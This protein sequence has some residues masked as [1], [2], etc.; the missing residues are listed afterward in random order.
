VGEGGGI[1]GPVCFAGRMKEVAEAAPGRGSFGKTFG[2]QLY[3]LIY[4]NVMLARRN[5]ISTAV[6]LFAPA[7]C[8]LLF[9]LT[10]ALTNRT[11]VNLN[12]APVEVLGGDGTV[13]RK[14]QVFDRVGG[15]F[16]LGGIIPNAECLTITYS[17]DNAETTAIMQKLAELNDLD[18]ATDFQGFA[19]AA[20]VRAFL[21]GGSIPV[22]ATVAFSEGSNVVKRVPGVKF[23]NAEQ[24]N[25]SAEQTVLPYEIWYNGTVMEGVFLATG[26]TDI[27]L[28]ETDSLDTYILQVQRSVN[29]A[30]VAVHTGSTTAGLKVG[31]RAF[32]QDTSSDGNSQSEISSFIELFGA[33]FYLVGIMISFIITL[34]QVVAE[35]DN[36]ILDALRMMGLY[37]S[38]YWLSWFITYFVMMGFSAIL[39]V[40][41]GIATRIEVFI[42]SDF[43]WMFLLFW[44]Y[45]LTM[46]TFAMFLSSLIPDTKVAIMVGFL[47]LACAVLFQ[48]FVS[49]QVFSIIDLMYDPY[50]LP[51]W[52]RNM[53]NLYPPLLYA[54]I[55][56]N[57]AGY[58]KARTIEIAPGV[59][60]ERHAQYTFDVAKEGS[61]QYIPLRL[62]TETVEVDGAAICSNVTS[63]LFESCYAQLNY[64]F[65][66]DAQYA[67][68]G[69]EYVEVASKCLDTPCT[70]QFVF[71][72]SESECENSGATFFS[73]GPG[74]SGCLCQF[75]LPSDASSLGYMA[76]IMIL[77]VVG[78][79]YA[80]QILTYGHG[81]A[82]KP[83]FIFSPF[84]WA[85]WLT[86]GRKSDRSGA[87]PTPSRDVD[88]DVLA[89]QEA[90]K[91]GE[92]DNPE[93]Y[94]IV[95]KELV[96]DFHSGILPAFGK[97]FRAVNGISISMKK[98][99]VFALLGHNGA[100]KTTAINMLSGLI[101]ISGGD[102]TVNG[103][104]VRD[105][106]AAIRHDV[107]VCPQFDLLFLELTAREHLRFYGHF[108]GMSLSEVR[109]QGER[110][111][112][113]VHLDRVNRKAGQFSGGMRRRLSMTV[114]AM[115]NKRICFLDEPSTGL[116]PQ[117]T[118]HLWD[119]I[120]DLKRSGRVVILTTH[121]LEEADVLGDKI[122]IMADGKMVALG[123]SLHLKSKFGGQYRVSFSP[124][125][126]NSRRELHEAMMK[127]LPAML[128]E[129]DVLE[130]GSGPMVYTIPVEHL[131]EAGRIF[132]YVEDQVD[133]GLMKDMSLAQTSLEDI[134]LSLDKE[135]RELR[136]QK[137]GEVPMA[138][139]VPEAHGGD[140]TV[141]PAL[142]FADTDKIEFH[143]SLRKQIRGLMLKNFVLQKRQRK[144]LFC[145]IFIPL[146]LIALMKTISVLISNA[147]TTS[148][149]E[150][151]EA[152]VDCARCIERAASDILE[153]QSFGSGAVWVE[154]LYGDPS[155]MTAQDLQLANSVQ[156][157][158][159]SGSSYYYG[160]EFY[161]NLAEFL[162]SN[163]DDAAVFT[164]AFVGYTACANA[165]TEAFD[166]CES[167]DFQQ[168]G[169]AAFTFDLPLWFSSYMGSEN[170]QVDVTFDSDVAPG[171]IR[172]LVGSKSSAVGAI[173]GE[174][175][176]NNGILAEEISD[177]ATFLEFGTCNSFIG[178]FR[179]SSSITPVFEVGADGTP[180]LL[181]KA[182]NCTFQDPSAALQ[183]PDNL[184][185]AY[186]DSKG[187]GFLSNWPTRIIIERRVFSEDYFFFS[188]N[189][190]QASPSLCRVETFPTFQELP[191]SLR[192][193]EDQSTVA[194]EM[195]YRA[196][197]ARR[198]G[199]GAFTDTIPRSPEGFKQGKR[200]LDDHFPSIGLV[201]EE[202]DVPAGRATVDIMSYIG[203]DPCEFVFGRYKFV[204]V[205]VTESGGSGSGSGSG[206]DPGECDDVLVTQETSAG[207]RADSNSF[208]FDPNIV[209]PLN[210]VLNGLT[211]AML[212]ATAGPGPI[213]DME[214]DVEISVGVRAMPQRNEEG[215][216]QASQQIIDEINKFFGSLMV[217]LA[218]SFLLPVLVYTLVLEKE[219]KLR[220]ALVQTGMRMKAY[221]IV[222]FIFGFGLTFTTMLLIYI[223]G[224]ALGI[225]VF[226]NHQ[227]AVFIILL[228]LWSF[229]LVSFSFF[230]STL[231]NKP[232]NS[233]IA[234]YLLVFVSVI[235]SNI[236]NVIVFDPRPFEQAAIWW[237]WFPLF[238]YYRA[239]YLLSTRSYFFEDMGPGDEL[240]KLFGVMFLQ[241]LVLLALAFYFD[242]V[243]PKEFGLNRQPCFC[244]SDFHRMLK[245]RR[246][247]R[248][249]D[250]TVDP[251]DYDDDDLEGGEAASEEDEDPDV[252][253][254]RKFVMSRSPEV[255]ESPIRIENMV[256]V[257]GSVRANDGIYLHVPNRTCLGLLGANGSGKTTL[258]NIISG[259]FAPTA[260]TAFINGYSIKTDMQKIH[261]SLGVC[262][263]HD[264]VYPLLTVREHLLL[265]ARMKGANKA[266]E[267]E[268]VEASLE[269]VELAEQAEKR[270]RQLSGG[271]RR[272]LSIAIAFIGNPSIVLLDEPSTGIDVA[273]AKAIGQLILKEKKKRTL[274]LTTHSMQEAEKLSDNI[275][276]MN[277]GKLQAIGTA[278]ALK[279]KYSEGFKL[280]LSV[281]DRDAAVRFIEK[282]FPGVVLE[283][284]VN[285]KITFRFEATH[286]VRISEV[287]G[288][289]TNSAEQNGISDFGLRLTSLEEVFVALASAA[290]AKSADGTA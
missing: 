96:K 84:Y 170:Q 266:D 85:P 90:I 7:V 220:A 144:T 213:A 64:C 57:M 200:V 265:Y 162:A 254:E 287:Y 239:V 201:F 107:S 63:P 126:E 87:L 262:P 73:V 121:L 275:A 140:T 34:R 129:E 92:H 143:P 124:V 79:W 149:G 223:L 19:N 193:L 163:P 142:N 15:R 89:E 16:G 199:T 8:V 56:N 280:L 55:D 205:D 38:A 198:E 153:Y 182:N 9:A 203:T 191:E 139:A 152:F 183:G 178:T 251:D 158:F 204:N 255:L 83:W 70:Q 151:D 219:L 17:P 267:K 94:P 216:G 256:R 258:T 58:V 176:E 111:L 234:L 67:F 242:A 125:D 192:S 71:S 59:R 54:K 14:C 123:D 197:K 26:G 37:E 159:D 244:F 11:S 174:Q 210:F 86:R 261:E 100:G 231:F 230:L 260:G 160:G 185:L 23:S 46:S 186:S 43:S 117:N 288:L 3:A 80:G 30:I 187:S 148:N 20:A 99:E 177:D 227:A 226:S 105:S 228:L 171:N 21:E 168:Q 274:I 157:A 290:E 214:S 98:G 270:A 154:N 10:V 273:T 48:L 132:R 50:R 233:N 114:A 279:G 115:G 179:S 35:K 146:L 241:S 167:F 135:Q 81:R 102:A 53:I 257:F 32:A 264:I 289:M 240:A 181:S 62:L 247:K 222:Q 31:I 282:N 47:F 128:A 276:I 13:L 25:P 116:D 268:L 253:A 147:I 103:M 75:T 6:H 272:R 2:W 44:I 217:P 150:F 235:A 172:I 74:I 212:R 120:Q 97:R 281:V 118:R 41:A 164:S 95:L 60:E 28:L 22:F 72:A 119:L 68:I 218:T 194:N 278:N 202:L 225:K 166:T 175:C 211:S 137:S 161:P 101:S 269:A 156:D 42:Y 250:G 49:L 12:P 189:S 271:Q 248:T 237:I 78:A 208:L 286:R 113:Q 209:T 277:H 65:D 61:Y 33:L 196:Q 127:Q 190:A 104:S 229:L 243:I 184:T 207:L 145:Q 39:V 110:L 82:E 285:A 76:G 221:W 206:S 136:R 173:L 106:I 195:I 259:L 238:T 224:V 130:Q 122:G 133:K 27:T 169:N 40:V 155:N 249:L 69:G 236:V 138:V 263:Q 52:G 108:Q 29:E 18:F 88:D 284:E 188:N 66:P 112:K 93:E 165:A 141:A 4:K 134:F 131:D 91:R 232:R 1:L 24:D 109:E 36:K 45:L 51:V 252:A 246:R 180:N 215:D 77:Y 245:N 283:S 5:W